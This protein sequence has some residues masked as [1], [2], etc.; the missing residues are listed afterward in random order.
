ML[1][2]RSA[3]KE[4]CYVSFRDQVGSWAGGGYTYGASCNMLRASG[5]VERRLNDGGSGVESRIRPNGWP[6]RW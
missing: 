3:G 5:G 1:P 6:Q 4:L 2:A